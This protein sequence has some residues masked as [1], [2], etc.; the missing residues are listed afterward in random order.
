MTDQVEEIKRKVDIVEFIGSYV[1]LKRAGRNF[2]GLCPFHK[3]KSPSFYVSQDRQ[4]WYCFG[5]CKEGGDVIKFL[6]KWENITFVEAIRELADKVGIKLAKLNFEDKVWQKRERLLGLN[7][8]AAEFFEYILGKSKFGER[9]MEYLNKRTINPKTIKKFQLG[10]APDS[11]DSLL[12][13]LLKKKYERSEIFEAGLVVVGKSGGYYDRFRS[14]II[15]PIKDV[16][17]NTIG[18]S[19]RILDAT[20]VSAKYI[21][22]PETPLYHKRETLYGIDVVRDAIRQENNVILVEG[23]FDMIVPYEHGIANVV[24][25]KG[26]A[27]TGEQLMMLKRYTD[28][29]TLALDSDEAGEEAAKRGIVQAEG[30]DLD[31]GVVTFDFGKDPDEAARNDPVK[32]KKVIKSPI[33]IYDFII[34]SAQKKYEGNDP[35]SKKKLGDVVTPF[36]ANIKNPIVYSHYIKKLAVILDVSEESIRALIRKYNQSKRQIFSAGK[37]KEII[38]KEER[39]TMI[40]KYLLSCVFQSDKP[41]EVIDVMVKVLGPDDFSIPSNRKLLVVLIDFKKNNPGF[42]AK[43]FLSGLPKELVSVY[44]ELYLFASADF[45]F[46]GENIGKLAYEVKR[47]SLKRKMAELVSKDKELTESE[48]EKLTALSKEL[49][50]VEKMKFSL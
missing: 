27:V 14:R 42:D 5:A 32:F 45:E 38:P 50:E 34:N 16:R 23:E 43:Y 2:R 48:K 49:K 26:S 13:F 8:L 24:A 19:G 22:T 46:K 17:G 1:A 31:V 40:Q 3:E 41:Y 9:A 18:F 29:I 25:I 35:F 21:N 11:W 36:I 12:K 44:D 6:M 4:F 33:P 7:M 15:F 28:R 37:N 39:D 30:F 20:E 47:F 10:Y